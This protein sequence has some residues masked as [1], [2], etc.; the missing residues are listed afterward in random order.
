MLYTRYCSPKDLQVAKKKLA[1]EGVHEKLESHWGLDIFYSHEDLQAY[2]QF[3][4]TRQ[5]ACITSHRRLAGSA[6]MKGFDWY[7]ST[8]ASMCV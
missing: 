8:Q 1:M 6:A 3:V 7:F 5:T 2:R 4:Y